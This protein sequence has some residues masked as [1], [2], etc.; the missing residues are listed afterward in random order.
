M[1]T[2]KLIRGL[3]NIV[4]NSQHKYG[5]THPRIKETESACS[6]IEE[7]SL[8]TFTKKDVS[9]F[10]YDDVYKRL[11][12]EAPVMMSSL[13]ASASNMKHKHLQVQCA[14]CAVCAVVAVRAVDYSSKNCLILVFELSHNWNF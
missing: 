13:L 8:K 11:T 1:K 3:L 4:V 10:S 5:F 14:K 6:N 7:Q 12:K 9:N 2:L